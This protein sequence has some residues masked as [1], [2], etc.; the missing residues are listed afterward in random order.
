MPEEV[1]MAVDLPATAGRATCP[2]KLSPLIGL[3]AAFALLLAAFTCVLGNGRLGDGLH[4]FLISICSCT[5]RWNF[6][7]LQGLSVF[8]D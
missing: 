8:A 3:E 7:C 4:E 1:V 6:T 2:L 5:H